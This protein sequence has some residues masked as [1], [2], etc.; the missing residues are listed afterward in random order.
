ME[1]TKNLVCATLDWETAPG[2]GMCKKFHS[3]FCTFVDHKTEELLDEGCPSFRETLRMPKG[4]WGKWFNLMDEEVK[5]LF[6]SRACEFIDRQAAMDMRKV[7]VK[8]TWAFRKMRKPSGEVPQCKSGLCARGVLAKATCT[9]EELDHN[10]SA[11][12]LGSHRE[13]A[14][15]FG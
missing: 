8:S 3:M 2:A 7:V 12:H 15:G 6:D 13:L 11:L 4:E 5:A 1:D 9:A 14:D 10:S